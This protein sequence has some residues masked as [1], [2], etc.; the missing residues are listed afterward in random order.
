MPTAQRKCSSARR[1]AIPQ[2]RCMNPYVRLGCVD[3]AILISTVQLRKL[4]QP[5]MEISQIAG[6]IVEPGNSSPLNLTSIDSGTRLRLVAPRWVGAALV[7]GHLSAVSAGAEHV[8]AHPGV[9][10]GE[11]EMKETNTVMALLTMLVA[12][13]GLALAQTGPGTSNPP[14]AVGMPHYKVGKGT[15]HLSDGSDPNYLSTQKYLATEPGY[16]VGTGSAAERATKTHP[17]SKSMASAPVSK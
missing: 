6:F 5:R 3:L 7:V 8:P 15:A 12:S 11:V 14:R 16:S 10:Q 17:R 13:S 4:S 2:S 9:E 1:A